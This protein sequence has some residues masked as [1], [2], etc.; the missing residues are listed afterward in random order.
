MG[1]PGMAL[2]GLTFVFVALFHIMRLDPASWLSLLVISVATRLRL[3]ASISKV[4]VI[5]WR[6]A[7]G[8]DVED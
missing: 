8:L 4:L 7:W 1:Y 2:S 6:E 5:M 3:A